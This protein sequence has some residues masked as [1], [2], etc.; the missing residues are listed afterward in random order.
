MSA[1]LTDWKKQPLPLT[2]LKGLTLWHF[3]TRLCLYR[4]LVPLA[5]LDIT[6]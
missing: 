3:Q 6:E 1:K 4:L 5:N 2:L